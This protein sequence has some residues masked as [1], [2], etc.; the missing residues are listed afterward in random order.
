VE[1]SGKKKENIL[2]D[3]LNLLK[4]DKKE[5]YERCHRNRNEFKNGDLT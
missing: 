4:T 2:K 5:K 1:L 3:H